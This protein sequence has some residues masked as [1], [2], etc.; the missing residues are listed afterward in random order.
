MT[1]PG[2]PLCCIVLQRVLCV[3]VCGS[4]L[5]CVSVCEEYTAVV[6]AGCFACLARGFCHIAVCCGVLRC[7]AVCCNSGAVWPEVSVMVQSVAVY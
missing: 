3:A 2:P 5:Q 7:V 6:S 4:V 1:G